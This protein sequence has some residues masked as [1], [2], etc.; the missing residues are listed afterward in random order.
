MDLQTFLDHVNQGKTIQAFS[1]ELAY[2]GYLTQEALKITAVINSGYHTPEEIQEL[3]AEL[4]GQPVNRTLGLIPPFHTDCGKNIHLGEHVFINAGCAFQDQGGIYIGDG[5]LIGHHATIVTLNHDFDPEKRSALHPA[6]VKIGKRVWLGANVTV[7]PG[8][9]IGD[10]AIVAAGA[11]VT[12]DVAANTV[13]A[14][15]PAR[16]MKTIENTESAKEQKG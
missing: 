9:S 11:V 8:V 3:F 4:T 13:V 7:L 16:F 12:K 15:V 6:P 5:A 2:S 14:G 10:G 1:E